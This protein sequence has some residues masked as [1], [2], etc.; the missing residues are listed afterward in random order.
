MAA[1][2]AVSLR[3]SVD[4]ICTEGVGR[5]GPPLLIWGGKVCQSHPTFL[6]LY[7]LKW[8]WV[9]ELQGRDDV[10]SKTQEKDSEPQSFEGPTWSLTFLREIL[11]WG[12]ASVPAHYARGLLSPAPPHLDRAWAPALG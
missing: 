11:S 9:L 1:E 6:Y 7:H 10:L 8:V 5:E 4:P 2:R 3:A 12:V